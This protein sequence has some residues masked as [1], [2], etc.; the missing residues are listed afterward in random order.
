VARTPTPGAD[1]RAD[2]TSA[3]RDAADRAAA[4]RETAERIEAGKGR[5]TPSRREQEAARRRPL[6]A[7]RRSEERKA[8]RA[9]M[10]A[11]RE[12]ARVGM[13]NGEE[14]YLPARDRGPQKRYVRDYIDARYSVGEAMIPVMVLVILLTFIPSLEVQ[15]V[16]IYVL[17]GFVLLA[18]G[19]AIVAG[20]LVSRRLA[21]KFGA[22]RVE[23]V[24]WYAAMRAFQ[25]RPMRLPKPQVARRQYPA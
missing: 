10:T 24:R 11:A 6:V 2:R 12:R 19:D 5:A 15:A 1:Q 14:R 16:G 7:D 23:R 17:W 8:Q 9:K 18:I 21:A 22:D 13:A 4:D 25:L 20:H 3:A